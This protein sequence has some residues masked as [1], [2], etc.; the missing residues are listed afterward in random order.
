MPHG[1]RDAVT[2]YLHVMTKIARPYRPVV[3]LLADALRRAG[4]RTV[5]D[6]ASGGSG[7]WPQLRPAL[8]RRGVEVDVV[9]TD[10]YPNRAAAARAAGVPGVRYRTE[11][12]DAV[13][14]PAGL[15]GFR[16][17]FSTFH[18]FEPDDAAALLRN[19]ATDGAGIAVFEAVQRTPAVFAGALLAPFPLLVVAPLMRPFRVSRLFWTYLVP[20]APLTVLWDAMASCRKAY[21]PDEMLEIARAAR[22]EYDWRAGVAR[23]QPWQV[24][25]TYLIGT[26]AG[27]AP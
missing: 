4:A 25:V 15:R 16:T 17:L 26:P 6:L 8:A 12:V 20:A 18:H 22:A 13:R 10:L 1:V 23:G 3:D 27:A 19:A 21:A 5:V 9:L 2:D 11:P 7:P 24:P 14:P